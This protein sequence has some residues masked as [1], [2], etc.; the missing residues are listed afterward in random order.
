MQRGGRRPG[1]A[2][3]P[4]NSNGQQNKPIK[5]VGAR[6]SLPLI[7]MGGS[8][9]YSIGPLLLKGWVGGAIIDFRWALFLSLPGRLLLV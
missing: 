6:P 7:L 2:V 8:P 4:Y 1:E 9:Y 3:G 5:M